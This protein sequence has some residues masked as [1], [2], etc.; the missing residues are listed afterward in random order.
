MDSNN[1]NVVTYCFPPHAEL[2]PQKNLCTVS[3][4]DETANNDLKLEI[5]PNPN[6]GTFEINIHCN[7]SK[8]L[9][10]RLLDVFGR[11]HSH[12]TG[13]GPFLH[14][15]ITETAPGLYFLVTEGEGLRNSQKVIIS[16]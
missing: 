10:C 9:S 2:L 12:W 15:N 13:V 11:Q 14:F 6:N 3:A 8:E 1:L 16:E 5:Y 4:V 7:G